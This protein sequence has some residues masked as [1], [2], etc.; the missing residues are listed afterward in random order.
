MRVH[1]HGGAELVGGAGELAQNEDTAVVDPRGDVLLRDEVHAVTQSGDEHDVRRDEQRDHLLTRIRLVQVADRRVPH[2]VEVAVDAPDGLLDLVAEL[3]VR[4]DALAARAGDLHKRDVLDAQLLLGEQFP[5]GLQPVADALRVVETVDAEEDP[6]RI[7]EALADLAC[8]SLDV[9]ALR[10]LDVGR[11]IDRDRE[12]LRQRE[13]GRAVGLGHGDA[14]RLRVVAQLPS[15]GTGEVAGIRHS[16][17]A[18]DVGS[19]ESFEHLAPPRQLRIQA[20]CREGNV[21][22]VADHQIRAEVAQHPR[23]QLQLV[24]LHPDGGTVFGGLGRR[25]GESTVDAHVGVPP[26]PSVARLGDDVVVKRPDRVVREAFVVEL[27]VFGAQGDRHEQS[28]VELE[29]LQVDVR[30]TGPADP[31]AV[32]LPHDRLEGGDQAARRPP[33][34]IRPVCVARPVHREPVGDD[35]EL[36]LVHACS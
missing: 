28:A 15:H 26:D 29:G 25:L 18:D 12:R 2:R 30:L 10:Q 1:A 5:V 8:A 16:L 7:A 17:E 3:D 14:G 19:E 22:E 27:D 6:P 34:G 32:G 33:P 11:R 4:G 24:V 9:L 36:G 23:H 20:V 13:P 31:R 35:H 21:V